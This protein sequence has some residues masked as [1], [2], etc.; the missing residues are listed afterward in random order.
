MIEIIKNLLPSKLSW[1]AS[2]GT[3]SLATWLFSEKNASKSL[4]SGFNLNAESIWL[5]VPLSS[6]VI[7]LLLVIA[8]LLYF[9]GQK[10][11]LPKNY[12][13]KKIAE[14]IF[15]Y[16]PSEVEQATDATHKLCVSCFEQGKP[17]TLSQTREPKRMIGL[18]CPNG[19]PKLVFTHYES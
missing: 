3:I 6:I 1:L 7:G 16:I 12:S 9:I 19:C 4:V 10:A 17:S 2:L 15:A 13:L 11:K 5:L 18:V 14:G 8:T